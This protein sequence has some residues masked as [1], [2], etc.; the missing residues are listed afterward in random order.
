MAA[1]LTPE[2]HKQNTTLKFQLN[3]KNID[4]VL[5]PPSIAAIETY[6]DVFG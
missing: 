5:L 3:K 4:V 2:A 6:L 1:E